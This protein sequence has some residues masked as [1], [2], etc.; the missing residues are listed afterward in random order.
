MSNINSWMS[1]E[2]GVD[3]VAATHE[4]LAMPNV[5]IHV[6]RMVHTPVGSAPSGMVMYQ[7]D[8]TGAPAVMGFVSQDS[9]VGAYFGPRIFAGTPFENVAVLSATIETE[10]SGSGASSRVKVGD[11]LFEVEMSGLKPL[12]HIRRDPGGMTPFTQDVVEAAASSVI[13]KVN[14][15]PVSVIVPPVG[16]SGGAAAVAALTGLYTR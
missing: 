12:E 4:G 13:V 9:K 7:P 3:L 10:I 14:G 1:W 16:I 2:G 5:L 11:F 8:P 15:S 6:A